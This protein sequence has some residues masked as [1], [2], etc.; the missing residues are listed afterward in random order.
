MQGAI[1]ARPGLGTPFIEEEPLSPKP[2]FTFSSQEKILSPKLIKLS[3]SLQWKD[4][5]WQMRNRIRCVEKLR[6]YFPSMER[7]PDLVM[8]SERFPLAITPYYAS[9]IRELDDTDPVFMMS[10]PQIKE[11]WSPPFL[12]EDPLDEERDMPVPGLVHRYPDRVL[13]IATSVCAMYCRYCTRKRVTGMR[14]SCISESRIKRTVEYLRAHPEIKDVVVSGG[15]PLTMSTDVL[16]SILAALRSVHSVDIIRIGTKTPVTMPMRITD[17]LVAMLRKYHPLWIN[18]HFNHPNEL[19]PEAAEACTKLVDAGI[20][21][22]NQSVLLKGVNDDPHI[23]EELL[24][25]LVRM[26]VRPYYLF[27]CDLVEGI[28]HFRTPLARGV[29]IMEYLRG[30]L[31]G[32]AIPNFVVDMPHG[33]G[34]VPILPNYVVSMSPTHSVLRNAHGMLVSYPEPY[35]EDKIPEK[36]QPLDEYPSVWNLANGHISKIQPENDNRPVRYGK[37]SPVHE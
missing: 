22:G 37:A 13:L 28:E 19:T 4:W 2:D 25:G 11:L 32:I 10:M 18:T 9:L 5:Q 23:M 20:P 35:A 31:S 7:K 36:I 26:R 33:G 30:R 16:E 29:E 3:A 14:E 34:K 8:A 17:E 12:R 1:I 6:E 27:Q 24:R 15:D 21:V